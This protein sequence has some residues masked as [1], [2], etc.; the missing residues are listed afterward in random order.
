[1]VFVNVSKPNR[2]AMI[3]LP[4]ENHLANKVKVV[5]LLLEHGIKLITGLMP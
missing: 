1:M 3:S 5:G 2:Q 4:H